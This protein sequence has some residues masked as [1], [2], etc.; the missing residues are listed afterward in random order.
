LIRNAYLRVLGRVPREA[1]QSRSRQHL[2]AAGT[3]DG[4]RDLLWALLNTQ[5]FLTNH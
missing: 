1:E 4:L 3:R 5:E 2:D